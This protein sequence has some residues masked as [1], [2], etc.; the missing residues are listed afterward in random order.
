MFQAL[1]NSPRL[2][3]GTALVISGLAAIALYSGKATHSGVIVCP[4]RLIFSVP[5]PSCG[6]TRGFAALA[7]GDI[8]YAL[9]AN[10]AS[11]L[12]FT[13]AV[14]LVLGLV[15]QLISGR[16]HLNSAWKNTVFRRILTA[17]ILTAMAGAWYVNLSRHAHGQGPLHLAPASYPHT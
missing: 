11:P 16:T 12:I 15:A 6:M 2:R 5:C 17:V 4:S 3:A 10:P 1:A 9:L 7:H 13:L 8:A 14:L